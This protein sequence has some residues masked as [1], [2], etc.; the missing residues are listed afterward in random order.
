M[1]KEAYTD[2][3]NKILTSNTKF[4]LW[5]N[6]R[7]PWSLRAMNSI[8]YKIL[9]AIAEMKHHYI[10]VDNGE[11]YAAIPLPSSVAQF[12]RNDEIVKDRNWRGKEVEKRI[13]RH[14]LYLNFDKALT[15]AEVK[16]WRLIKLGIFLD[17]KLDINHVW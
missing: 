17:E 3:L 13:I 10:P 8:F 11:T 6:T 1:N 7:W 9:G 16:M 15:D 14:I 4:I 2:D 5:S 12:T